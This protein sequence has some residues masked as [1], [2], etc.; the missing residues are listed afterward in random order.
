[1]YAS[2][3]GALLTDVAASADTPECHLQTDE[4]AQA[5]SQRTGARAHI[6]RGFGFCSASIPHPTKVALARWA[7]FAAN[8]LFRG[9]P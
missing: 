6:L 1:M 7:P 8:L 9:I 3:T 4:R 2:A 5:G